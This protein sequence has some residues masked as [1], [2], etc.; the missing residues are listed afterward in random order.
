MKKEWFC[1]VDNGRWCGVFNIYFGYRLGEKS[2]MIRNNQAEEFNPFELNVEPTLRFNAEAQWDQNILTHL[3]D[4]L[5]RSGIK[6]TEKV[7]DANEITAVKYHLE[8]MRK[9]VFKKGSQ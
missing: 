4:G 1:Y 3:V 5:I 2:Y 9:L 8:D 6:P 7:P